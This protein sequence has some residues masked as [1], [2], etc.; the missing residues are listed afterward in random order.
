M[1]IDTNKYVKETVKLLKALS[2]KENVTL[3]P[4]HKLPLP[5]KT[6]EEIHGFEEELKDKKVQLSFVSNSS[7]LVTMMCLALG[8]SEFCPHVHHHK[9]IAIMFL[10][11]YILKQIIFNSAKI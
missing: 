10:T 7:P 1:C 9:K 6:V 2:L 11:L 5:L 3:K 4:E 8:H